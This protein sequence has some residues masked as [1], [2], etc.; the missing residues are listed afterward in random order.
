MSSFLHGAEHNPF[1]EMLLKERIDHNDRYGADN[2]RS[3]FQRLRGNPLF[4][5]H[6]GGYV[7]AYGG[8]RINDH[9][10]Q[11]NLQRPFFRIIDVKDRMEKR[12]PIVHRKEQPERRKRRQ[13]KR[14][15]HPEPY[16]DVVT[17]VNAGRFL[18]TVGNAVKKTPHQQDI[19]AAGQH[20]QDERPQTVDQTEI[21]HEQI[22]RN[23]AGIEQERK[24]DQKHNGPAHLKPFPGQRVS[25]R[26]SDRQTAGRSHC[27]Q[28][29]ADT[30]R[31]DEG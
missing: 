10:P 9:I 5:H 2:D 18:Q 24:Q 30:D 20:R 4:G 22:R 12:V 8:G 16:A 31:T 29:S 3:H 28:K 19:P 27:G 17:A 6:L 7:A 14:Q 1:G 25:Q 13:G 23:D 11:Q 15:D 21:P 26:G